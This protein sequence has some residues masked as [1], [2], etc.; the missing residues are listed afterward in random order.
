M[1]SA[2]RFY[3]REDMRCFDMNIGIIGF[4]NLGRALASG[5]IKSGC[6]DAGGIY[7]CEKYPEVQTIAENA[8]YFAHAVDNVNHVISNSDVIFLTIKSYVFEELSEVIARDGLSGKILVSFMAGVSFDKIYSLVGEV[9]LVRAMPSLAIAS[10]E[11]VIGYTKAPANVAKIFHQLG[12]AFEISPED[13]EKVMAFSSCGLGFAAYLIDA[14]AAAGASMGFS[15]EVSAHIAALTFKNAVDR[16]HFRDTVSAVATPGGA[17][18]Q[19][20]MHMDERGIYSIVAQAIGKAYDK[21][22]SA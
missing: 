10:C 4:G 18:E 6:T 20:I 22:A 13:I 16:G 2:G 11:G 17:T 1:N 3:T 5:L 19:G 7:V 21:M 15:P 12:Y 14:F 9:S 8:P